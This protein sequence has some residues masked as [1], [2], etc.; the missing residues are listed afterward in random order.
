MKVLGRNKL[1]KFK[2]KHASARGALNAWE[3][4]A[5]EASWHKWADIKGKFPSADW[6]GNNR[7]VFNIKGNDYRLAVQVVFT[8]SIVII[9][10]VGTHAEYDKWD[11]QGD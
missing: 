7:V 10:R 9:E 3:Q 5:K 4:E 2:K 11:L 8:K 1:E 6:L